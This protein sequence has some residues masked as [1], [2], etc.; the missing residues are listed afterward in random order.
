MDA[1]E[2]TSQ[3]A[4]AP[5]PPPGNRLNSMTAP[6]ADGPKRRLR[7]ALFRPILAGATLRDRV[8]ACIGALLAIGATGFL[9]RFA[10][11]A[12][13]SV[14]L[15]V[16]PM[17]ASA[18]LLFAV[19]AS[20]LAQ[21]WP[22]FGGNAISALV[23]ITVAKFIADPMLGAAAAI[24]LAIAA[25]SLL[26]CL[27]PPGGAVALT[28][29]LGDPAIRAAGYAFALLPVGLNTA[30]MVAAAWMFHRFSG[31]SY[32]HVAQTPVSR[33]RGILQRDIDEALEEFGEAL[34]IDRNDLAALIRKAEEKAAA[35]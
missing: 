18:V 23:G 12:E 32:P 31:H 7:F 9:C 21:P 30:L 16:A 35:R 4:R 17:G 27:H 6:T 13:A 33:P 26:R 28:A 25:M 15:L 5:L 24:A 14:P 20:P 8:I 19:P 11:G 34:D 22:V 29:V 2:D 10:L 3:I 1:S